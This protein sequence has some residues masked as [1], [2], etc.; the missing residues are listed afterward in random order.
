MCDDVGVSAFAVGC[1]GEVE[2]DGHAVGRSLRVI[3]GDGG[4]AG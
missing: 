1:V 2:A 4:D 3:V